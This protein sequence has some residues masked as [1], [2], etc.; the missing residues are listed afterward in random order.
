MYSVRFCSNFHKYFVSAKI[1][2]SIASEPRTCL[3]F[4]KIDSGIIECVLI[5]FVIDF[6]EQSL[7]GFFGIGRVISV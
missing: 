1:A 6:Y 3:V 4:V 7:I 5:I 2:K